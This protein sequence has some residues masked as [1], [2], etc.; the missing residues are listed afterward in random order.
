MDLF[1]IIKLINMKKLLL[2]LVLFG[3]IFNSCDAQRNFAAKKLLFSQVQK[4]Y[5]NYGY[6]YNPKILKNTL[7]PPAG[8]SVVSSAQMN[9]IATYIGGINQA[10]AEKLK[11]NGLVYWN[12]ELGNN[13]SGFGAVGSGWRIATGQFQN[14]KATWTM[15]T[16]TES[17]T[18]FFRY[19]SI[20]TTGTLAEQLTSSNIG[21]AVRLV[22]NSTILSEGQFST[23]TGNDGKIYLTVCIAGIEIMA[24]SLAETKYN[25]GS[26]IPEITDNTAWGASTS[27]ARCVYN[28]N[29]SYR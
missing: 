11:K 2:I 17:P 20:T 24:S 28:N 7:F 16:N 26:D 4:P 29:E 27:G 3:F 5:I 9:S 12:I 14:I 13:S 8:Y 23:M 18:N 15:W 22:K 19:W 6:L 25:D 21:M 10:T 1:T